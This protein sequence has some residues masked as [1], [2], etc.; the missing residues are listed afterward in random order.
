M[1]LNHVQIN[2]RYFLQKNLQNG[3]NGKVKIEMDNDKVK[4]EMENDKVKIEMENDKVKVEVDPWE[5]PV[6]NV[7]YT[8]WSG[9]L[10]RSILKF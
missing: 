9:N 5:L 7:V 2:S 1:F 8:K 3:E 6:V 4:K 10:N